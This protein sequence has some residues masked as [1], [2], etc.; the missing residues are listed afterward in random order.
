MDKVKKI[1]TDHPLLIIL[2]LYCIVSCFAILN[3]APLITKVASPNTLWIKQLVFYILSAVIIFIVYYAGNDVIYDHIEIIYYICLFLL[4]LLAFDHILWSR[5]L[6]RHVVPFAHDSGGAT[7]WFSL[8]GF[9]LQPSE[10]M[11]VILVILLAKIT[12]KHNE[13][14]LIRSFQ[15]EIDYLIDV[16]KYV[17]PPVLFTYLQ[18]DTGVVLIMLI[19]VF[20]V[21]FASALRKEWFCFVVGFVL[22]IIGVGTYLF[23]YQHDIFTH[24][25]TGHKLARLYGWIDPE[26]TIANEGMQLFYALISYGSSGWF[27][28]GFQAVIKS[29]PE[30]QT[31]FIFAVILTNYGFIGGLIT[32]IL[33]VV[34]DV[35]LLKIG[36]DSTNSRDKFF[37]M[38]IFGMLLFQQVWNMGMILGLLPI[39]GITL[40]FISYGGSSLLSYMLTIGMFLDI[41]QQNKLLKNKLQ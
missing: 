1:F 41:E 24:I 14:M 18:N 21:I 27:G 25:V 39:T 40:P 28:H 33:V 30:A 6:G 35:V 37:T 29:F 10:F 11:K 17:L 7:M 34:F 8:P 5:F 26:G 22:L 38:G 36:L 3:A 19:G 16:F 23:I 4:F 20:F 15:F 32:I 2:V 13:K 31:D 9:S 12:K